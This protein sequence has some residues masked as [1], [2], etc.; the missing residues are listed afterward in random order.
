MLVLLQEAL[1]GAY[2]KMG[3][4]NLW[5]PDLRYA[6]QILRLVHP[7]TKILGR[8]SSACTSSQHP[9]PSNFELLDMPC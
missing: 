5:L 3:L 8:L 6:R 7:R 9:T 2:R 4:E 1:V